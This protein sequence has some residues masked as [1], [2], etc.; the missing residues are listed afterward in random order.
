MNEIKKLY[1]KFIKHWTNYVF[2]SIAAMLIVM[3][4]MVIMDM[5]EFVIISSIGATTFIVF[6]MPGYHVAKPR[7]IVGGHITGLFAGFI[8]T[9]L[10]MQGFFWEIVILGGA[11][12]LSIFLM[13]ILDT[14]H[15]PAS[16]TAL[17][18]VLYGFSLSTCLAVIVSAVILSLMHQL[19]GNNIR[20]LT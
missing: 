15:P 6:A 4:I 13:V 16:G 1:R 18:I 14:E 9:L 10:P 3:L 7:N 20:D 19:L 17:G 2:Q 11:V 5:T 8:F 12:G